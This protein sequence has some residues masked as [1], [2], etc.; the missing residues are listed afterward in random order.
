MILATQVPLQMPQHSQQL[1]L[2]WPCS[3]RVLLQHQQKMMISCCAWQIAL[4]KQRSQLLLLVLLH[5]VLLV[6]K[7]CGVA[8][9]VLGFRQDKA[10]MHSLVTQ[11]K[12]YHSH[13][14]LPH[15]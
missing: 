13:Q 1:L 3:R 4:L 10:G 7:L 12:A 11:P 5:L 2:P 14:H 6:R 9:F 15:A 8:L